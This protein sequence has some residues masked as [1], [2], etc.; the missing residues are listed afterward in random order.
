MGN[1]PVGGAS[2]WKTVSQAEPP[3]PPPEDWPLPAPDPGTAGRSW[4]TGAVSPLPGDSRLPPGSGGESAWADKCAGAVRADCVGDADSVTTVGP[5]ATRE[6]WPDPATAGSTP[7]AKPPSNVEMSGTA[8]G[9]GSRTLLSGIGR[10]SMPSSTSS[11][12]SRIG[13]RTGTASPAAGMTASAASATIVSAAAA[14]G[15]VTVLTV[16]AGTICATTGTASMT[17]SAVPVTVV[18]G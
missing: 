17:W 13:S 18:A 1:T 9:L 2:K 12:G 4:G 5:E 3:E 6:A 8:A 16:P 15:V 7:V 10:A 11:T 14:T